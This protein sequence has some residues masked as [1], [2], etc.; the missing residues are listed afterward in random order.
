M[1]SW[2]V[3]SVRI[4]AAAV[5]C[6][7]WRLLCPQN[8]TRILSTTR[9]SVVMK[10]KC[11]A[12]SATQQ[13]RK[14]IWNS[15]SY[16][17]ASLS[18]SSTTLVSSSGLQRQN[19]QHSPGVTEYAT[20]VNCMSS[21]TRGMRHVGGIPSKP[22]TQI[23][24]V[25]FSGGLWLYGCASASLAHLGLWAARAAQLLWVLHPSHRHPSPCRRFESSQALEHRSAEG[26]L[27]YFKRISQPDFESLWLTLSLLTL[28]L[29]L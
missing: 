23:S 13:T 29:L 8:F 27:L 19:A 16:S 15:C 14:L 9:C 21:V 1:Y 2:W 24:L 20:I 3:W 12:M 17:D 26:K 18:Q 28:S 5:T 11:P 25:L 7:G 22:R 10:T 4:A 6:A